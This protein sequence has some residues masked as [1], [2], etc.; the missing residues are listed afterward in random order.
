M[1]REEVEEGK[2]SVAVVPGEGV[3]RKVLLAAIRVTLIGTR[4]SVL[5]E[6][7]VSRVSSAASGQ[8]VDTSANDEDSQHEAILCEVAATSLNLA[9]SSPYLVVRCSPFPARRLL[10]VRRL[11]L[12]DPAPWAPHV[13]EA[14]ELSQLV[15]WA[16]ISGEHGVRK[17]S[18]EAYEIALTAVGRDASDVIFVDDSEANVAGAT[19]ALSAAVKAELDAATEPVK[20]ALGPKLLDPYQ[21]E[22]T[23]RSW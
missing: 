2:C 17:P 15:Q 13:E 3:V 7:V 10:P 16:F 14:T 1:L 4:P 22:A 5:S 6:G 21:G 12:A 18:P 9:C 20:A 23:Q 8:S 19:Y 11:I